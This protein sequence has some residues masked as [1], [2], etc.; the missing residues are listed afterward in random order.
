MHRAKFVNVGQHH[1][2]ALR[3][4]LEAGIA[5]QRVEPDQA[6]AGAVQTVHLE[7]QFGIGLPL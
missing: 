7:G 5:Q 3:L 1:F 2:D 6:A 4:G